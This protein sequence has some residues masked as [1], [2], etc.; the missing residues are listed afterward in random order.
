M[1]SPASVCCHSFLRPAQLKQPFHGT[2]VNNDAIVRQ[3]SGSCVKDD[4]ILAA[5]AAE[6]GGRC[7]Q[8]VCRY[9][10]KYMVYI[11]YDDGAEDGFEQE[12]AVTLSVV[13][14]EKG[15]PTEREGWVVFMSIVLFALT[16]VSVVRTT[17]CLIRAAY[18]L[19]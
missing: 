4:G 6:A 13:P 1:V 3:L 9:G 18:A 17:C 5:S 15:T 14:R 7:A 16:A 2:C 10:D 11:A 19:S 12:R 8:R